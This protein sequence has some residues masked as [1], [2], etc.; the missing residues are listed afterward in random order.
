MKYARRIGNLLLGS[1]KFIVEGDVCERDE[2]LHWRVEER[3][4]ECEGAEILWDVMSRR[5]REI[6]DEIDF[7]PPRGDR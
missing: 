4:D 6:N 1:E 2:V 3:G 7:F 5:R